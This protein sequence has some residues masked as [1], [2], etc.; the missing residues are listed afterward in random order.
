MSTKNHHPL[1]IFAGSLIV[2]VL[3]LIA[4]YIYGSWEALLLVLLLGVFEVSL[5]FDNAVINARILEKLSDFWQKL[6]LTVGILIAVFGM[7][8]LFPLVIV[9]VTTGLNPLQAWNLAMEGGDIATEG[10][11]ANILHAAHPQIAGF[12]GIFLLMLFLDFIFEERDIKWLSWIERPLAKIG[13][14]D[15]AAVIVSSAALLAVSSQMG[16]NAATVLIAG[17]AGMITYLL[18]N[19][20]GSYFENRLEADEEKTRISGVTKLV[21]KAAFF[22]FLY[23]EVLDASF[24]FDGVIGA[25]AISTDPIIIALGLGLIGAMFVRS[26]T[27]YLVRKGTL[28]DYVY[29]DHGAHWAIGALAT[30]LIVSIIT[31][32]PEIVIGLI[33]IVLIAASFIASVVR[34]KRVAREGGADAEEEIP[35]SEDVAEA[36]GAA[37]TA[38]TAAA[39]TVA[40]ATGE[41]VAPVTITVVPVTGDDV[42]EHR[43]WSVT[44]TTESDGK[45]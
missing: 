26:I 5:S 22:S 27:I 1:R 24:S 42:P 4:G 43:D 19:A 15:Y 36:I 13:G 31:P 16:D 11:Y 39:E 18:V 14:I 30:L 9:G 28:N 32:V 12:G 35:T 44:E 41:E 6:F 8:I 17:I 45:L 33:G 20:L 34:N 40:K 21:G 10:T 3:A 38:A 29:L 23:L 37:V 25:L 7:R 2:T